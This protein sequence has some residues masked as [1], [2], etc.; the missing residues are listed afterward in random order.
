MAKRRVL[1]I[2]RTFKKNQFVLTKEKLREILDRDDITL[3]LEVESH[4]QNGES[5]LSVL[6]HIQNNLD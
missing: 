6:I 5:E 2:Q 1:D 3:Y 4:Y